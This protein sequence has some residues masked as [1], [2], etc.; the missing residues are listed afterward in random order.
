MHNLRTLIVARCDVK[1]N[2]FVKKFSGERTIELTHE[3][4][5]ELEEVKITRRQYC[6]FGSSTHFTRFGII[7]M[8]Y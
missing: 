7:S 6:A 1:A 4:T 2:L 3:L 5:Y 8:T